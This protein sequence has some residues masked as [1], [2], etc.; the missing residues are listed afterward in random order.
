M[1]FSLSNRQ[2]CLRFVFP[3]KMSALCVKLSFFSLCAYVNA[4]RKK[5]RNFRLASG[6]F[7]FCKADKI[8]FRKMRF[9][10]NNFMRKSAVRRKKQKPLRVYVKTSYDVQVFC[11]VA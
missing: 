9:W 5:P 1:I 2:L 7:R 3:H 6:A 11:K 10:R 4:V 8:C